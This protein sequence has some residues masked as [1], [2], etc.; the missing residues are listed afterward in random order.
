MLPQT[1]RRCCCHTADGADDDGCEW[2]MGNSPN[3]YVSRRKGRG[4][5][6]DAADLSSSR[7]LNVSTLVYSTVTPPWIAISNH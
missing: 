2:R 1:A 4:L 5:I 7:S 6:A 3:G